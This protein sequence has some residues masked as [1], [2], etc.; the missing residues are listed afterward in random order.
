MTDNAFDDFFKNKLSDHSSPVPAD[1]WDRIQQKGG[2]RRGA[3]WWKNS[4]W[5]FL[6]IAAFSVGGILVLNKKDDSTKLTAPGIVLKHENN[7]G[8]QKNTGVQSKSVIGKTSK[9]ELDR[10]NTPVVPTNSTDN[11]AMTNRTGVVKTDP[12]SSDEGS[13]S[14]QF[15]KKTTEKLFSSGNKTKTTFHSNGQPAKAGNDD[16]IETAIIENTAENDYSLSTFNKKHASILLAVA[17]EEKPFS[18]MMINHELSEHLKSYHLACSV[19]CPSARGPQKN[20]WYIEVFASPD[21]ARKTIIK[22]SNVSDDFL[23]RKDSTETFNGAF[24]A[25]IRISKT[26]GEKLMIKSGVQFSQ[27]NEK[28]SYKTENERRLTTV[29][30]IRTIIRSPGDTVLIRDTSTVEQIGYRVKTTYNRYRS[31]DIPVVIGYEWGNEKLRAS[32]NAGVILNVHSWQRGEMLDTSLS[33]VSFNK[34]TGGQVFK[35]NIGLGVYAGFSV[36]KKVGSNMEIFG[37]PYIRYNISNMTN[38][39]NPFTQKFNVAGLNLGIRYK[40][41]AMGQRR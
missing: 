27:I 8:N 10:H 17:M 7:A 13:H 22:G 33:T 19:D 34:T 9:I 32:V 37:E 36:F 5:L 1:M 3:F 21:Y 12:S 11:V 14:N 16:A 30:T 26:L 6:F 28:F 4:A 25:G 29:I 35:Q 40:L 41:S 24:T 38:D 39:K 15:R 31:I 23:K 2:N 20:D 18:S